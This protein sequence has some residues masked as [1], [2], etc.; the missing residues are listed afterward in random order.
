LLLARDLHYVDEDVYA[1]ATKEA[2]GVK[3]MLSGLLA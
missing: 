1:K 2:A 3:M